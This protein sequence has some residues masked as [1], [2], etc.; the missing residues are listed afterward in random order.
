MNYD[1]TQKELDFINENAR[2]NNRQQNIFNRLTDRRRKAI[3]S[4]N[5]NGRKHINCNC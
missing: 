1:F 3:N 5:I 4:T 2:F